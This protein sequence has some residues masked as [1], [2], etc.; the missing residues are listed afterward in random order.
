MK[1]VYLIF[2][3]KVAIR[4]VARDTLAARVLTSFL[5]AVCALNAEVLRGRCWFQMEP[6]EVSRLEQM[7]FRINY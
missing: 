6:D 1:F 3:S 4:R 2:L 5:L 7:R